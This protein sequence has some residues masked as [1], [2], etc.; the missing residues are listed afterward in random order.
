MP[1]TDHTKNT[2]KT[3][4][5]LDNDTENDVSV[6]ATKTQEEL[7]ELLVKARKQNPSNTGSRV[8]SDASTSIGASPV[9]MLSP[10]NTEKQQSAPTSD[11]AQGTSSG[12]IRGNARNGPNSK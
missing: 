12:T 7:V 11:S 10:T 1:A 3:I 5:I 9:A 2:A 8:A 4:E 6:L